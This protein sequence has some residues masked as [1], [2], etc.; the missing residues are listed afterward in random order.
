M[1][2]IVAGSLKAK[3]GRRA[4]EGGIDRTMARQ[5]VDLYHQAKQAPGGRLCLNPD[6]DLEIQSW[7]DAS[8]PTPLL[9]MLENF[10]AH[11]TFELV[12]DLFD[13]IRLLPMRHAYHQARSAGETHEST[14][15]K[16][17]DEY[18]LSPRQIER[19][20]HTDKM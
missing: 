15:N 20:V 19:K 2:L 18:G 6:D 3:T 9:S 11:G 4:K 10:A 8:D 17:A 5:W 14:V 7:I 13:S 12:G 1:G 16:L